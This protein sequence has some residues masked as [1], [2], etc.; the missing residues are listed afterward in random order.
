[1]KIIFL[2]TSH[3]RPEINRYCTS[4]YFEHNGKGFIIDL[5]APVEYLCINKGIP[6]DNIA[7][8]FITHMHPDHVSDLPSMLKQASHY[9]KEIDADV[10][11]PEK[12]VIEP[13][14]NWA[15]AIHIDVGQDT[16]N[17]LKLKEIESEGVIYEDYGVKVTAIRTE[18]LAHLS[19]D[20]AS[21]AYKVETDDGKKVLFTGDLAFNFRDYPEIASREKFDVIVSELVHF[22]TD[23]AYEKL[24][25]LK[26]DLIIFSH[27]GKKNTDMLENNNIKFPYKHIV[28][29]DGFE[30]YVV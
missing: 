27:L 7:A 24:K 3:G 17:R 16:L 8:Y 14:L 21:Y 26:T 4:V 28:A 15:R 23:S 30:H 5:G 22:N 9:N 20:F 12:G 29:T 2:G 11:I 19:K 10:Y 1:M 13:L 25:N 18:H 6:I